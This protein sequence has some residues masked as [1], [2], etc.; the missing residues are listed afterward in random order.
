MSTVLD[1]A[2]RMWD[3]AWAIDELRGDTAASTWAAVHVRR[4]M[5]EGRADD[6]A[7]VEPIARALEERLETGRSR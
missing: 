4:L 1:V 2:G 6:P 7:A 3:S 5:R